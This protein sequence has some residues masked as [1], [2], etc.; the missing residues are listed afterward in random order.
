MKTFIKPTVL[1]ML[2]FLIISYFIVPVFQQPSLC[3]DILA[4]NPNKNSLVNI[5]ASRVPCVKLTTI[6][7]HFYPISITQ[8]AI[9]YQQN[10]T[11]DYDLSARYISPVLQVFF[12]YVA[13][14]GIVFCI[15]YAMRSAK[16]F[17]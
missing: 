12:A 6:Q 5:L 2:F 14:C 9:M 4:N 16:K 8:N 1:K 17:V 3:L 11:Y 7:Q 13:S 15:Y 10:A